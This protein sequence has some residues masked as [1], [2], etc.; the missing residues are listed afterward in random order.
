MKIFTIKAENFLEWY[1]NTG[2][3]EEIEDGRIMM[4]ERVITS[5]INT[6]QSN[7]SIDEIFS[8]ATFESLP[9][10][11]LEEFND[12]DDVELGDYCEKYSIDY[13][14]KLIP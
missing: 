3:D 9:L 8:E 10:S 1:F 4:G 12:N 6:G 13:T 14:I 2:S 7:I 5:L 11:Y